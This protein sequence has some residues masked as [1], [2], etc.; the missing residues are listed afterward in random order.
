[1]IDKETRDKIAIVKNGENI[2]YEQTLK[3]WF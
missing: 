2:L 3:P 1:V